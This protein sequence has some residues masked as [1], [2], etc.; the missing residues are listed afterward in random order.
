MNAG[1]RSRASLRI[2]Q[3]VTGKERNRVFG[4]SKYVSI[5]TEGT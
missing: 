3:E 2:S 5:L 4:D 1:T